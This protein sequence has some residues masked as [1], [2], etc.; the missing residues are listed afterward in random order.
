MKQPGSVAPIEEPGVLLPPVA[1]Q[2]GSYEYR[3]RLKQIYLHTHAKFQH[4][5]RS[6]L[7]ASSFSY[8]YF[9]R[10]CFHIQPVVSKAGLD[11]SLT[12]GGFHCLQTGS[13]ACLWNARDV[14]SAW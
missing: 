10:A 11:L 12:N 4:T 8:E 3:T 5:V 6:L 1:E 2:R 14:L 9:I 13:G 7:P